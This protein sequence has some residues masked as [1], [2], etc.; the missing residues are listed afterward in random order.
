MA[1]VAFITGA[2]TGMGRGVAESLA[3]QQYKVVIADWNDKD[4][5]QLADEIGA[6]FHKVDVT[7]W[8]DQYNALDA[9]FQKY[10]RIDF[11]MCGAPRVPRASCVSSHMLTQY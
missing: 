10:G 6:D 11:G 3:R 7:S 2:A 1:K 8:A 5:Q 9:T 4:G